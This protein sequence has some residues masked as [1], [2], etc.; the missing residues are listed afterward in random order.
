MNENTA[1]P[2][3]AGKRRLREARERTAARDSEDATV[4]AVRLPKPADEIHFLESGHVIPLA[5][6][7]EFLGAGSHITTR[8]ETVFVTER[9][10]RAA[11]DR[12]GHPGWPAFVHDEA[13]Q[14]ER[15]GSVWVRAGRAPA[16]MDPWLPGTAEWAEA[17][18]QARREAHR[19][20][21]EQQ[22]A[23]ALAEVHRRFGPAP[24]TSVTLNTAKTAS[25]RAFDEQ[26]NR[27]RAAAASGQPNLGPSKA[28]A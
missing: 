15:Y 17:R 26:Q 3:P 24:T 27:I 11:E 18:E 16:D 22:R 1:A 2:E 5:L 6:P 25:E 20:P 23:D 14:V 12:Y 10:I 7:E 4:P 28:S 19:L 13:A 9:M 8:G 21:A